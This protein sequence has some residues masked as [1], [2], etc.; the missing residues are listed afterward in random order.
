MFKLIL[1]EE[2]KKMEIN[3]IWLFCFNIEKAIQDIAFIQST[4]STPFKALL[5]FDYF[6][7][8][9]GNIY[10]KMKYTLQKSRFINLC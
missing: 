9:K 4:C 6:C 7:L 3:S 1:Q 2:A 10:T 5:S 8:Q